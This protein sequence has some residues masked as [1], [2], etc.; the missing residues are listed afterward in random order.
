M[1]AGACL[2]DLFVEF[3]VEHDRAGRGNGDGI[4][5][6]DDRATLVVSPR[7]VGVSKLQVAASNRPQQ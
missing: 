5:R 2:P 1:T 3:A 4:D 6:R 7:A